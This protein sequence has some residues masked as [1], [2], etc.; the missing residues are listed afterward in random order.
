MTVIASSGAARTHGGAGRA[1][2]S[3]G[4]K[5]RE[6]R[7]RLMEAAQRL[8]ETNSPVTLT[9]TAIAQAA[10]TSLATFYVY[11]SDVSDII[12]G[13][14]EEASEDLGEVMEALSAWDPVGGVGGARVFYGAYRTYWNKHRAVLVLR[15]MESDRGDERFKR[16]RTAAGTKISKELARLILEGHLGQPLSEKQAMAR[17]TVVVAAIERMASSVSFYPSQPEVMSVDEI[18]EAQIAILDWLISG[19]AEAAAHGP[20]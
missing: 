20:G 1:P 12:L 9:A 7:L 15:N 17:A 4:R 16:V 19:A 5:G 13:L 8:L 11:F 6:T 2:G 14:A 10:Q 3:L 18:D